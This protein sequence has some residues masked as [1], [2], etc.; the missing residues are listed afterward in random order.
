M[1]GTI[2]T[3]DENMRDD[4]HGRIRAT[5]MHIAEAA[6]ATAKV[7]IDKPYMVLN[8]DPAL[9]EQ[10]LPTLH[11]VAG[12]RNVVL[13]GKSTGYEDFAFFAQQAPGMFVFLGGS[14]KGTDL[15][16][17]AYNHSPRFQID[18]SA[19]KLGVRTLT[20]LT[21]DYMDKQAR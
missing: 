13:R 12:A 2:R 17:V 9:T 6:G 20:Y 5:A 7:D 11:R 3:F 19:L 4:I 15:G 1:V 21:L 10:M 14:P 18:E 16:K 8:N